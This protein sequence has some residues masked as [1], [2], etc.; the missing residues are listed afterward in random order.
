MLGVPLCFGVSLWLFFKDGI[1]ASCFDT[2]VLLLLE[3]NDGGTIAMIGLGCGVFDAA[4]G[5]LL[6]PT[7]G[8]EYRGREIMEF[9]SS[10]SP[11]LISSEGAISMHCFAGR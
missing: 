4:G 5:G 1:G 8:E 3:K 2:S 7:E 11:A 6:L 9:Q 10:I